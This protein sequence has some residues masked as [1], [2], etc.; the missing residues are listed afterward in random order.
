MAS[1]SN[2]EEE[3]LDPFVG[4]WSYEKLIVNNI[5]KVLDDCDK[6]NKIIV[7]VN[8]TYISE[9]YATTNGGNCEK[10]DDAN[11]LWEN[12]RQLTYRFTFDNEV[13]DRQLVFEGNTLTIIGIENGDTYEEIFLRN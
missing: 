12:I 10:R 13:N 8:G 1:C 6:K 3:I 7:N 11:G 2:N 9:T 4:T 5:E